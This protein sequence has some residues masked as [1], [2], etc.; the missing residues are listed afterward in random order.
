MTQI[1]IRVAG[2]RA[3]A[4][5]TTVLTHGLPRELAP[6]IIEQTRQLCSEHG[7]EPAFTAVLKGTPTVGLS[8]QELTSLMAER[9][10]IKINSSNLGLSAFQGLTGATTVS[11]T[12][13]LA[14][15]AGIRVAATGGIGGVHHGYAQQLDISSDLAA[16][17]RYPVAIVASGAKSVLDVI[18]TRE[19]LETLGVPV[20][21]TC[22]EAFPAFYLTES[23]ATCDSALHDR[24]ELA[25]FIAYET[26]RTGRGLLI[27]NPAPNPIRQEIW[28]QWMASAT[29]GLSAE[30]ELTTP[31]GREATPQILAKIHDISGG[32][33]VKTNIGLL[34]SNIGVAAE[35]AGVACQRL[36]RQAL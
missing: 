7:I 6:Q 4:L 10:T 1:D 13:E 29:E 18:S 23:G 32:E 14:A 36:A 12:L 22:S 2:P 17:S 35:L 34:L 16:L 30:T 24:A 28:D 31:L 21:G 9:E 15:A 5:E 26:A 3:I 25:Q 11:T 33:T 8:D 27:A 19:L 20:V